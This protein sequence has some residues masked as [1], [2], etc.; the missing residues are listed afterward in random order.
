MYLHM[1]NWLE[2]S[3]SD[4]LMFAAGVAGQ[5][6]RSGKAEVEESAPVLAAQVQK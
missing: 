2:Y 5:G 1:C 6:D 4:N 3:L